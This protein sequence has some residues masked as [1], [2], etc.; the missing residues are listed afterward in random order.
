M[1]KGG[2]S[3]DA[4]VYRTIYRLPNGDLNAHPE[5]VVVKLGITDGAQTEI[6]E[7]INPGD[8]L[9]TGALQSN[10]PTSSSPFGGRGVGNI[11]R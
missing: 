7:G 3:A 1:R 2:A 8:V 9:I 6:D 4:P 5:A 10:N 11:I